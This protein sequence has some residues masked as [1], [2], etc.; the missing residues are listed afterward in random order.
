[1]SGHET[2]K[3]KPNVKIVKQVE[4]AGRNAAALSGGAIGA[5]LA[6]D[7]IVFVSTK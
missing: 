6:S 2:V 5:T 4:I 1:M 7:W 3:I